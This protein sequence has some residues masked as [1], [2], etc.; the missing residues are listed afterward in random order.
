[1]PDNTD[2]NSLET[3]F[4]KIA[5]DQRALAAEWTASGSPEGVDFARG[6]AA[7]FDKAADIVAARASKEG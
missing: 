2:L 5:E 4:R 7:A 3:L 1:M 6:W